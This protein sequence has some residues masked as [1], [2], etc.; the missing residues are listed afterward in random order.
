MPWLTLPLSKSY[1]DT[2]WG[3]DG[4]K[5]IL[6]LSVATRAG[7]K[8]NTTSRELLLLTRK[9]S[10][11]AKTSSEQP[12]L[13]TKTRRPSRQKLF[14]SLP[15]HS[16]EIAKA[17]EGALSTMSHRLD[18]LDVNNSVEIFQYQHS[19]ISLV[20]AKIAYFNVR[21]KNLADSRFDDACLDGLHRDERGL[22]MDQCS[23]KVWDFCQRKDD[24]KGKTM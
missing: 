24:E 20:S 5:I 21:S 7:S 19:S 10:K 12:S 8:T 13:V 16:Q 11:T 15:K 18:L 6:V 4:R 17:R 1:S 23:S 22:V 14:W 9:R 2:S 3:H